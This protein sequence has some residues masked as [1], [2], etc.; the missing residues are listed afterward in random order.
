MSTSIGP[1]SCVD[2]MVST[3]R[4]LAPMYT[5]SL[6]LYNFLRWI[7]LS[8]TA[9]QL[10]SC[11]ATSKEELF[12]SYV[13][14]RF[15]WQESTVS[16]L[17]QRFIEHQF[18]TLCEI[19]TNISINCHALIRL[20]WYVLC[21][22]CHSKGQSAS[23]HQQFLTDQSWSFYSKSHIFNHSTRTVNCTYKE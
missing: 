12:K 7:L 6:I 16:P 4:P 13:P 3:I 10:Q 23:F 14:I 1:A 2:N 9:V 18:W 21:Q 19:N 20:I 22:T 11:L 8:E 5:V 15:G 17:W